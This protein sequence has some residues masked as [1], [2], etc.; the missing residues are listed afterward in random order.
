[1]IAIACYAIGAINQVVRPT[2]VDSIAYAHAALIFL[3]LGTI[4]TLLVYLQ[5]IQ[6]NYQ[7]LAAMRSLSQSQSG[8]VVRMMAVQLLMVKPS[9]DGHSRWRKPG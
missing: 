7:Q 3:D 5:V 6:S 9:R 8:R 4:L 2:R 1:M